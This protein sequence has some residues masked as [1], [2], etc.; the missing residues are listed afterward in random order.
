MAWLGNLEGRD[1]TYSTGNDNRNVILKAPSGEPG[2]VD[3]RGSRCF[4]RRD[5]SELANPGC[6]GVFE[7]PIR[8]EDEA[9]LSNNGPEG[10]GNRQ[11]TPEQR[12]AMLVPGEIDE[13]AP[14]N[15]PGTRIAH[16]GADH[17]GF[18]HERDDC[19]G[20]AGSWVGSQMLVDGS[21]DGGPVF[22]PAVELAEQVQNRLRRFGAA[23]HSAGA[24]SDHEQVAIAK[25]KGI[26]AI[27]PGPASTPHAAGDVEST[28]SEH[29][30]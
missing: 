2:G 24:V 13:V 27:L 4:N 23:G 20:L 8:T 22:G 16:A 21:K 6:G 11:A 7:Q 12:L 19:C 9:P 5:E 25:G 14:Q 17:I 10:N 3:E 1:P 18:S 15:Q 26:R 29:V 28:W 30:P